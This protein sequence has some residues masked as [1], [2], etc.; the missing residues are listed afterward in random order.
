MGE[1]CTSVGVDMDVEVVA[2]HFYQ[3]NTWGSYRILV[4]KSVNEVLAA[5]PAM[6]TNF[7]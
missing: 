6:K 3:G 2:D 4:F 7:R 1:S 5:Y